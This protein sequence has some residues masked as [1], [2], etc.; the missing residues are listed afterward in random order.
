MRFL[1]WDHDYFGN[2]KYDVFMIL[3]KDE[4]LDVVSYYQTPLARSATFNPA[5]IDE[6]FGSE[7]YYYFLN[8]EDKIIIPMADYNWAFGNMYNGY[9]PYGDEFDNISFNKEEYCLDFDI[10]DERVKC[11]KCGSENVAEYL[12]GLPAFSDEMQAKLDAGK[13]KLGGCMVYDSMPSYYCNDCKKKFGKHTDIDG[14]TGVEF[15]VGGFFAGHNNVCIFSDDE[16]YY[17]HSRQWCKGDDDID[18][19]VEIT[20]TEWDII[21]QTLYDILCIDE[22]KRK[23]DNNDILD[24]TQWSLNIERKNKRTI[25]YWGSNE[26]PPLWNELKQ[27][28]AWYYKL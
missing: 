11:P 10:Y 19:V 8:T 15:N 6:P 13:V 7:E 21:I 26:Y 23:Y 28:F 20:K 1:K 17:I 25:H 5:Y 27:V 3:S 24:G 12:Y 9:P 4:M 2:G 18:K 14:I 16:R 22:W